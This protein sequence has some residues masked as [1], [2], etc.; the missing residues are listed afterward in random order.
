MFL[1]LF[2]AVV[3][4]FLGKNIISH[5][6]KEY[7]RKIL[8]LPWRFVWYKNLYNSYIPTDDSRNTYKQLNISLYLIPVDINI[9]LY[10]AT[11]KNYKKVE[12]MCSHFPDIC[13]DAFKGYSVSKV[14]SEYYQFWQKRSLS[15]YM[16]V[17]HSVYVCRFGRGGQ[18][19]YAYLHMHLHPSCLY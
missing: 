17:L 10:E 12:E 1:S 9:W 2:N 11:T 18:S 7:S 4:N 13:C 8:I 19:N 15:A 5:T 6:Y 16:V 3:I 14:S